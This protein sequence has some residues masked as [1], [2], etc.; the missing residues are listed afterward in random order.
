MQ[1]PVAS[2]F[3]IDD[4]LESALRLDGIVTLVDAKNISRQLERGPQTESIGMEAPESKEGTQESGEGNEA[5]MQLAYADRVLIN[6]VGSGRGVVCS[7]PMCWCG[8]LLGSKL[9]VFIADSVH[10]RIR[11]GGSGCSPRLY[12]SMLLLIR[13]LPVLHFLRPCIAALPPDRPDLSRYPRGR[14][15]PRARDQRGGGS[16][17][18]GAIGRRP[19]LG[20]RHQV[21][22]IGASPADGRP[23]QAHGVIR[24]HAVSGGRRPR[25]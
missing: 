12:L 25:A 13:C 24:V 3:W 8:L 17:I 21:L 10:L 9:P 22:L 11:L 15:G 7:R 2:V 5:A 16:A 23:V 20:A 18:L 14:H 19:G 1:G 4:A 6:K